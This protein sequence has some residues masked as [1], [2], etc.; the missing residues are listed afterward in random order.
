MSI[1]RIRSEHWKD[2]RL[3]FAPPTWADGR[4]AR[5]LVMAIK[6]N[7]PDAPWIKLNTASLFN[8]QSSTTGGGGII[9]DHLGRP[10]VAFSTPLKATS[11]LKAELMIIFIF[12]GLAI[13]RDYGLPI[14]CQFDASQAISLVGTKELGP[15]CTR[16]SMARLIIVQRQC[17]CKFMF[18]H[19]EG[20]KAA[21]LMAKQSSEISSLEKYEGN[22]ISRLLRAIIRLDQ[23][24][25]PNI[26]VASDEE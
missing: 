16:H 9:R 20:K 10:M 18:I 1:G 7:P 26:R 22:S 6:W 11:A 13:A 5:P 19:R 23:I 8:E 4:R 24:G 14:W 17:Q 25:T 21:A 3:S 15:A 2:V 12:Q